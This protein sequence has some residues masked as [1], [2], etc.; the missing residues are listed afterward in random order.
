M[1]TAQT[2]PWF[3]LQTR[4]RYEKLVDHILRAKGYESFLPVYGSRRR[5]SDRVKLVEVPLLPGY[6]F[7]R[8]CVKERLNVLLTPG[9]VSVVSIGGRPEPVSE[10]EISALKAIIRSG[11]PAS[12]WPFLQRGQPIRIVRGPLRGLEGQ[13]L[14]VKT[15]YLLVVSVVLLQRSVAVD[16]QEDWAEP[17]R[18]LL[19]VSPLPTIQPGAE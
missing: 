14:R 3:A 12:P 8:L 4:P 2:F 11:F 6:T 10:G 1:T 5:W 7:C 18:P 17:V 19:R 16:I 13:L 9:V 15:G